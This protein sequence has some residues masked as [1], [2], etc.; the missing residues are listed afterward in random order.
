DAGQSSYGQSGYGQDAGQ[1]SYGQ[2]GYGQDA[3]QSS[4]GQQGYGQ[5]GYG[6]QGYSDPSQSYADP[7]QSYG[8]PSYGQP[9]YNQPAAY[10]QS[11]YGTAPTQTNGLAIAAMIVGIAAIVICWLNIPLGITGVILGFVSKGKIDES[12]GALGGRGMAMTGII[13]GFVGIAWGILYIIFV[14]VGALQGTP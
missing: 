1:S 8:Q 11:A 2:S 14:V 4:Y 7:S 12:G 5:S 3:G 10:G 6:Q 9:A 13:C